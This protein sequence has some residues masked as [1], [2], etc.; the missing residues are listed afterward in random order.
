M[1]AALANHAWRLGTVFCLFFDLIGNAVMH[2]ESMALWR[3]KKQ[4]VRL[5]PFFYNS[6]ESPLHK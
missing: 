4:R 1:H 6:Y 2:L 5:I 3:W